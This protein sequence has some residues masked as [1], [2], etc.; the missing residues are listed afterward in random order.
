[1]AVKKFRLKANHRRDSVL[2]INVD[3]PEE[4]YTYEG[5]V[6]DK[7]LKRTYCDKQFSVKGRFV[8]KFSPN[9]EA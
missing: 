6:T 7:Q 3:N 5:Y 4:F 2:F 1:M 9:N 8:T